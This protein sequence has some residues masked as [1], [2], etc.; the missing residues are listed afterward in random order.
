[1]NFSVN[2]AKVQGLKSE[3]CLTPFSGCSYTLQCTSGKSV[4]SNLIL[5]LLDFFSFPHCL[6]FSLWSVHMCLWQCLSGPAEWVAGPVTPWWMCREC[7][8]VSPGMF[9]SAGSSGP[10]CCTDRGLTMWKYSSDKTLDKFYENDLQWGIWRG[11]Q[12]CSQH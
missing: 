1:M 8:E 9:C 11:T 10:D 5:P 2:S 3:T 12:C 6:C 4:S 7:R